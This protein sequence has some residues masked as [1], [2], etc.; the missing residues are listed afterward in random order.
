MV[1]GW[2][3]RCLGDTGGVTLVDSDMARPR[4]LGGGWEGGREG[5]RE[6]GKHH[7]NSCHWLSKWS[8]LQISALPLGIPLRARL[9]FDSQWQH[10]CV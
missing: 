1:L 2:E 8:A 10:E 9:T 7:L 4:I 6:G 5:G 3:P